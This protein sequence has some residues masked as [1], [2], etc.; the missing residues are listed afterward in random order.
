MMKKV[1]SGS[2]CSDLETESEES[3]SDATVIYDV[4]SPTGS[5][6]VSAAVPG[7]RTADVW[8]KG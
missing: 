2:H 7:V 8:N 4:G 6:G 1:Y 3:D 5:P